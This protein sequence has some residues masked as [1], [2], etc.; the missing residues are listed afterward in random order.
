MLQEHLCTVENWLSARSIANTSTASEGGSCRKLLAT[1]GAQGSCARKESPGRWTL[2]VRVPGATGEASRLLMD[3]KVA[4]GTPAMVFTITF[5]LTVPVGGEG[6]AGQGQ[7]SPTIGPHLLP[8]G[9][10]VPVTDVFKAPACWR[11]KGFRSQAEFS[12]ACA[13]W[14]PCT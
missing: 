5:P 6:E 10:L 8:A 1:I 11:K 13:L 2:T 3:W 4:A 12:P 14:R 9:M 7:G